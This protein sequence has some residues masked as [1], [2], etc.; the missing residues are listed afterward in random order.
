MK[1]LNSISWFI[2]SIILNSFI[3]ADEDNTG[4]SFNVNQ[5]SQIE[6][7]P[8]VI[9][10]EIFDQSIQEPTSGTFIMYQGN[11]IEIMLEKSNKLSI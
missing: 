4:D 6:L 1:V 11:F 2:L 9:T 7:R 3:N 5:G 8:R 10:K